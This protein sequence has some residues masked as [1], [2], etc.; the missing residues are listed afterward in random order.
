MTLEEAKKIRACDGM[1]YSTNEF[2]QALQMTEPNPITQED[3][4]YFRLKNAL[5]VWLNNEG[6]YVGNSLAAKVLRDLSDEWDD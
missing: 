6:F 3:R 2:V 4:D 5:K 1:G